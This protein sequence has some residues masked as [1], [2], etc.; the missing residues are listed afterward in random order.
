MST[1]KKRAHPGDGRPATRDTAPSGALQM[2]SAAF[3]KIDAYAIARE[4]KRQQRAKGVYTDGLQYG[5]VDLQAFATALGWC[6]P[7]PGEK[8]V[9]LGS[10]SGKAVLAAAALHPFSSATGIE[11]VPQLHDTAVEALGRCETSLL[12][13]KDVHFTCADAL[14]F[15]WTDHDV[16]FVSITCF[17]DEMVARVERDAVKLRP[18][19]RML[20]TSRALNCGPLLRLLHREKLTYGRGTLTFL[21]YERADGA[22][23]GAADRS[24]TS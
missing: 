13:T 18:G 21:A 24:S 20:V 7:R 8:F 14:D 12:Q 3:G 10:G 2:V 5:E 11:L 15:V 17:T 16:V 4:S 9:D 1:K 22:E 19:A 23:D 6:K